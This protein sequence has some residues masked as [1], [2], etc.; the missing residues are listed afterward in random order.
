M[1]N[2]V[3]SFLLA[4]V[5]VACTEDFNKDVAD[6]QTNAQ[7][8]AVSMPD[9]A[10]QAKTD[11][12]DLKDV[13]DDSVSICSFTAPSVT[14]GTLTYSIQLDGKYTLTMDAD[15]KVDKSELQSVVVDLYGKRPEVRTLSGIVYAYVN[16]DG[17]SSLLK[18]GAIDI[19]IIPEAPFIDT[20]YYLIG[21]MN[22]WNADNLIQLKHSDKDVYEDPIFSAVVEVPANCFWKVI[23]QTNVTAGNIW[24]NNYVL[25]CVADGDDAL[26]GTLVVNSENG[27]GAMKIVNKGWVR[28]T[29]DMMSYT[30]KVE[31]LGN[32]SP[33]LYVPGDHQSWT[34]STAPFLYSQ[35]FTTY[36]GFISLNKEFKIVKDAVN[37]PWGGGVAYGDS[38]GGILSA[39]ASDN[40]IVSQAGLYLLKAN[41][42]AMTW[43]ADLIS[44]FG[45]IGDATIGGW[46]ASTPMTFDAAT[47]V[48]T[49]TTT[50]IGGKGFKFRANDAWTINLGGSMTDLT[51]DGG[52]ITV[53]EDGTYKVSLDLS[54][55]SAYKCTLVK[56]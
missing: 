21:D 35:D 47:S 44:T 6:P 50:L 22:T 54:N 3:Y 41:M 7:E 43:E 48:Y 56:Q 27:P 45:L 24:D 18:S 13:T 30:Y 5:F 34:P 9:F 33:Y 11:A 32:V 49:V 42:G 46:D 25:G 36:S 31:E 1:K 40:L 28:I 10:A 14:E 26:E 15:S 4:F 39:S 23:P 2:L 12:I 17:Q 8:D 29:L 20:A 19:K 16:V 55:A 53:T 52:N 38:G 51:Q 37:D